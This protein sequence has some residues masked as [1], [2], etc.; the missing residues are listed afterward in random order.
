MQLRSIFDMEVGRQCTVM[1]NDRHRQPEQ[2]DHASI[3]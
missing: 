3:D 2:H 1:W